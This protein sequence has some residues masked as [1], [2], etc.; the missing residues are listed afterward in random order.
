M[1]VLVVEDELKMASLLLRG[2]RSNGHVADVT[3]TGEDPVWMAV[4]TRRVHASFFPRTLA[5]ERVRVLAQ[6]VDAQGQRLVVVVDA[7]LEPR[8]ETLLDLRRQLLVGGAIALVLAS[9]AG[10]LL[11]A[12][13]CGRS[14]G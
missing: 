9:L 7:S 12:L 8:A 14:S 11:A 10:Y 13:R 2:F 6:P 4:A 3:R 5:G 1:K